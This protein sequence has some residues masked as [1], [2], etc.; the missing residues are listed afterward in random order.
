MKMA[1]IMFDQM[2]TMDFAGFYEVVACNEDNVASRKIIE[3]NNG[4]LTS[5]DTGSCKYW[6]R[7]LN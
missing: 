6:I 4:V 5:I 1:Y 7:T 3:N 2:T